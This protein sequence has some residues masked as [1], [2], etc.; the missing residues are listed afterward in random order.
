MHIL[1]TE[2]SKTEF[3]HEVVRQ[4]R[5]EEAE[6]RFWVVGESVLT[7]ATISF[8]DV[9]LSKPDNWHVS[10]FCAGSKMEIF[11]Y[12]ENMDGALV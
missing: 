4:K 11:M 2:L 10:S 9:S 12:T 5:L 8:Y 6:H 1:N 3:R 7:I